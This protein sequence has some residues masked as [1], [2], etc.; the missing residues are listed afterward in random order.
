[1]R[2]G[3]L[4]IGIVLVVALSGCGEGSSTGPSRADIFRA[5][6]RLRGEIKDSIDTKLKK[7]GR[8]TKEIAC[9][10]R[11]IS[12]MTSL[13]IAKRVVEAAPAGNPSKESAAQV[14]GPLG[15]GCP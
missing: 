10:N 6:S 11:N 8:P 13:Q 12:A 15:R 7:L 5:Q 9:V 14:E 2:R 1:M 4:V 3:A